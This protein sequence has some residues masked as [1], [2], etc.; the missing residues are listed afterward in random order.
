MLGSDFFRRSWA[1][2]MRWDEEVLCGARLNLSTFHPIL[3]SQQLQVLH[4]LRS[5]CADSIACGA[6]LGACGKACVAASGLTELRSGLRPNATMH[7]ASYQ[8]TGPATVVHQMR[9]RPLDLSTLVMCR[10]RRFVV[11]D[12]TPVG[13]LPHSCLWMDRASC[14]RSCLA[15]LHNGRRMLP[16]LL[17]ES[18][19]T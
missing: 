16:D 18:L 9:S 4:L 13:S 7:S 10:V 1:G 6:A 12:R 2:S 19:E 17:S 11:A 8:A 15:G 3:H 14:W 5:P